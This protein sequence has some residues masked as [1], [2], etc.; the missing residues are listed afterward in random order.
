MPFF[1]AHCVTRFAGDD[2]FHYQRC[3]CCG[4][5]APTTASWPKRTP[6]AI[7]S[8]YFD[9]SLGVYIRGAKEKSRIL[10]ERGLVEIGSEPIPDHTKNEKPVLTDKEWHQAWTEATTQPDAASGDV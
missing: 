3:P 5:L 6:S 10:R 7:P 2:E 1:C 9:T 8:S 4:N